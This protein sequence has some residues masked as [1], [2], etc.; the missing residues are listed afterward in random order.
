MQV[1]EQQ[2]NRLA[3]PPLASPRRSAHQEQASSSSSTLLDP[4]SRHPPLRTTNPTAPDQPS[5]LPHRQPMRGRG[6]AVGSSMLNQFRISSSHASSPRSLRAH[7]QADLPVRLCLPAAGHMR[8]A[9]CAGQYAVDTA[10]AARGKDGLSL[11]PTFLRA[12]RCETDAPCQ[13]PP[14]GHT[15]SA[16]PAH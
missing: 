10:D 11:R 3:S 13:T 8:H 6:W 2:G 4:S 16:L 12:R 7:S 9:W 1:E 14:L 5:A 15:R